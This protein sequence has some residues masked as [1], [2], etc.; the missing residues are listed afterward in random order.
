MKYLFLGL[1]LAPLMVLAQEVT[2]TP[3]PMVTVTVP[4][5]PLA[6]NAMA[7]LVVTG[8]LGLLSLVVR[9]IPGTAGKIA[10]WIVDV[11]SANVKH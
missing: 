9:R 6:G 8:A 2:P 3:V 11:F 5:F 4:S 7:V 1:W 10:G